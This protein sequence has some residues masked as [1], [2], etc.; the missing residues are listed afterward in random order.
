MLTSIG[1]GNEEITAVVISPSDRI[2]VVGSTE[3]TAGRVLVTARYFANGEPDD[4]FGE[5]GISLIAVGADASAEGILEREDGTLVLSGSFE[6]QKKSSAML[7]GS[8]RMVRLIPVSV[9]RVSRFQPGTLKPAKDMAW[10]STVM[11]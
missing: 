2:T 7:G 1:N 3:G 11:V 8:V 5:Q 4:A 6:E 10:P 9:T